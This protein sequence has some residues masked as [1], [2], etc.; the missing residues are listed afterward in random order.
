MTDIRFESTK[1]HF[2][3]LT[4]R[5]GQ[6]CIVCNLTKKKEIHK[7][8]ET[9]LNFW[10]SEGVNYINSTCLNTDE[11]KIIYHHYD[12]KTE[13]LQ[14]KFYKSFYDQSMQFIEIFP[15]ETS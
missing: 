1:R 14:P 15:Q 9:L 10:Y 5:Y 3:L 6:P 11:S 2:G 7:Q 13:R 4:E 8:Q 12:L